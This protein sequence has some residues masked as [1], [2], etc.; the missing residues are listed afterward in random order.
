MT[1]DGKYIGPAPVM[2]VPNK[3]A[4]LLAVRELA[5]A[6]TMP[7]AADGHTASD[8]VADVPVS[9]SRAD[10]LPSSPAVVTAASP[11]S[12]GNTQFAGRE[13]GMSTF[14]M[15]Q[16]RC[17]RSS[18][19]RCVGD[20]CLMERRTSFERCSLLGRP[21]PSQRCWVRVMCS[22]QSCVLALLCC[23]LRRL[24]VTFLLTTLKFTSDAWPLTVHL[25][26][27]ECRD[28]RNGRNDGTKPCLRKTVQRPLIAREVGR[29]HQCPQLHRPIVGLRRRLSHLDHPG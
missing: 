18:F 21:T 9:P 4:M 22:R 2:P 23:Y 12:H 20:A 8:S 25:T 26:I 1:A 10:F 13:S 7:A 14:R 15:E 6:L 29:G 24:L 3:R 27:R 28:G 16:V 5:V 17:S 19:H 11:V